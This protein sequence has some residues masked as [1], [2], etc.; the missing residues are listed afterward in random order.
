MTNNLQTPGTRTRQPRHR[1]RVTVIVDPR[2]PSAT[3]VWWKGKA[4][5]CAVRPDVTDEQLGM[6]FRTLASAAGA[7]EL[8]YS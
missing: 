2:L 1:I 6:L 7:T 3:T 8:D 5:T 4:A